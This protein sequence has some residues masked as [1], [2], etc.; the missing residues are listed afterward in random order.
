MT[1]TPLNPAAAIQTIVSMAFGANPDGD[2]ATWTWTD[3]SAYVRGTVTITKG[4][5]DFAQT[6]DATRMSFTLNNT[7]GRFTPGN[8]L[9]P[10]W[11][12]VVR[13]VPVRVQLTGFGDPLAAPYERATCFVD[14]WPLTPNAGVIDVISQISA[15]GKL[16]RLQKGTKPLRS[17]LFRAI[18]TLAPYAYWPL[19]DGSTATQ[20]TAAVGGIPMVVASGTAGFGSDGGPGGV[21][22]VDFS[23]S[24]VMAGRLAPISPSPMSWRLAIAFKWDAATTAGLN[25]NIC[26]IVTSTGAI[27]YLQ[28]TSGATWTLNVLYNP[29]GGGTTFIRNFTASTWIPSSMSS[30][31]IVEFTFVQNGAGVDVGGHFGSLGGFGVSTGFFTPITLGYPTLVRPGDTYLGILPDTMAVRMSHVAF[32]S[33]TTAAP[34]ITAPDLASAVIGYAGEA[35]DARITRISSEQGIRATVT[36]GTYGSVQAMG[37][38][39]IATFPDILHDAEGTDLGFLHDGGTAGNLVYL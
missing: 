30:W 31:K 39:P 4:R 20:A 18:S 34:S 16:R 17:P 36:T 9:S 8:P 14:G 35:A 11:P 23:N 5:A 19:E 25:A 26:S 2:P 7:D 27:W 37:P 28:V 1:F 24:L 6:A 21:A 33:P 3:V 12:N 29:P 38:Q 13:N 22:S 32:A 15:S 10:Y